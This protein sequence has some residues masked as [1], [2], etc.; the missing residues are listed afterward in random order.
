VVSKEY[1]SQQAELLL[2]LAA[3]T[4]DSAAAERLRERA[5]HFLSLVDTPPDGPTQPTRDVPS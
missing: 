1:Y 3:A 4:S 5:N 2:K